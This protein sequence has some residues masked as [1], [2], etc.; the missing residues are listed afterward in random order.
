[1]ETNRTRRSAFRVIGGGKE[2]P[3]MPKIRLRSDETPNRPQKPLSREDAKEL[4]RLP[5]RK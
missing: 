4:H 2:Q 3:V 1:M 5:D